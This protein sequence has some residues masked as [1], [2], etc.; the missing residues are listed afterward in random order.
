MQHCHPFPMAITNICP[1]KTK[2]RHVLKLHH[3]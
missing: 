1:S 2:T 3:C